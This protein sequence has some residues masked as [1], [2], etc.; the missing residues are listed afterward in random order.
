MRELREQN[1]RVR[2]LSIL[3]TIDILEGEGDKLEIYYRYNIC[4]IA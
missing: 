3:P 4:M 1:R 2:N